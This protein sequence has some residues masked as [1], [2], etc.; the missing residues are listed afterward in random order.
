[1][2]WFFGGDHFL[3]SRGFSWLYY[4]A[5]YWTVKAYVEKKVIQKVKQLW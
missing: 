1:M 4:S 2:R 3:E 5:T